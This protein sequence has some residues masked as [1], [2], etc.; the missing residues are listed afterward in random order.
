MPLLVYYN[1][2][3]N[4]KDDPPWER[5]V[6]YHDQNKRRFA[7]NLLEIVGWMGERYKDMIKAWWFDSPYSLDTRGP[8]NSVTTDMTGFQFP[9]EQFTVA[10]KIGHPARLVTYNAGV[11]ET[12]LYAAHQDYWAG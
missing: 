11:N 1:H 4:S 6:G 3:C 12:F 10:A 5:A 7:E 8:H 2:S 9:W